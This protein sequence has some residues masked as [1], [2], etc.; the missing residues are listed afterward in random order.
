MS[1]KL[2]DIVILTDD[3]FI[4]PKNTNQYIK[5][6]L[7]EDQLVADAL[8]KEGLKV[9][10]VSWSDPHFDWG[11]TRYVIFRTTWDYFDRADEWKNWLAI[12]SQKTQLINIHETV[13][14]NMDKHY[15]R[16]LMN[17]GINVPKIK[18]I[19]VGDQVSLA[20]LVT[21][22]NEEAVILKP[23][24]SASAR[25]TYKITKTVS[26]ELE[27]T[28]QELIKVESMML[29]PFLHSI[30]QKGEISMMI[31]GGEFTH[32]VLKKPKEGDFRVQND[33]GGSVELYEPSQEEI[34]FAEAAVAACPSPPL[35]ARVDI[36]ED[37][38]GQLAL[39]EIELIEPEL[40]FR[41]NPKGA[42]VLGKAVARHTSQK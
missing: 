36:V 34:A 18:Y 31:I 17:R 38:N 37:N 39:I 12:V 20:H 25:H 40:W 4:N 2:Y 35:Y 6:I 3:N 28:F 9:N 30:P 21:E 11:S 41:L 10:R 27:H 1:T 26:A 8:I 42:I 24:F 33:F 16:D 32:A 19:E 14:W 15:L 22:M 29:Q 7:L 23:C 5:N 13:L